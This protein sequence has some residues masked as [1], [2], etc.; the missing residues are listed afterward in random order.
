MSCEHLRIAVIVGTY[1][2]LIH[3]PCAEVSLSQHT[4]AETVSSAEIAD[5]ES[6]LQWNCW[7]KIHRH[8]KA[9]TTECQSAVQKIWAKF[10]ILTKR[11]AQ[12]IVAL[13]AVR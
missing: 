13:P 1:F 7:V 9:L 10:K 4:Q 11:V 2:S 5:P 12:G 6:F 3:S 8:A